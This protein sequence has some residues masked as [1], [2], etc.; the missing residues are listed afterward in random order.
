MLRHQI[1]AV[2]DYL[3]PIGFTNHVRFGFFLNPIAGMG[4]PVGL[5]GTDGSAILKEARSR[6][7]I[8]TAGT[9]MEEALANLD[10]NGVEILCAGGIMGSSLLERLGFK[11][12]VIHD[13]SEPTSAEDTKA[14]CQAFLE[15]KVDLIVFCGGDGTARDVLD[16]VGESIPVLGVPAGVKMHSAVFAMKPSS[17]ANLIARFIRGEVSTKRAEVM[18]IDEDSYREGRISSRLYGYLRIP[19]EASLVQP[20]KGEYEG[21]SAEQEKDDISE[22][23]AEEMR[24]DV[25]YILG[26]GT[27]VQALAGKLN[28]PK[29]LLGVDIVK[30]GRM[31]L[32]DATENEILKLV[33]ESENSEIIVTPIGAQGFIFGR[34]NQ[35]ISPKVIRRVGS[36]K[37]RVLAAPTK[38]AETKV[39]RVD[40]GDAD[41]DLLLVGYIKVVVGNRRERVVRVE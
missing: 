34:G 25:L 8:P 14:I 40:S 20:V 3:L 21:A 13:P 33:E 11:F 32:K 17:A 10:L 6:G 39:L 37:I 38:L 4:G 16:I 36:K 19:Y 27:T 41:L 1:S 15:A 23:I 30:A 18:D 24:P 28:I 29:T 7:A 5:K 35:Q 12:T 26:P 2:E 31:I 22:Y 9:R